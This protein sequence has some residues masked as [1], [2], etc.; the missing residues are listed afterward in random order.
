MNVCESECFWPR[1]PS[2]CL[3]RNDVRGRGEVWLD[4]YRESWDG[5]CSE[6]MRG[7]RSCAVRWDQTRSGCDRH[8]R[9]RFPAGW[10]LLCVCMCVHVRVYTRVYIRLRALAIGKRGKFCGSRDFSIWRSFSARDG[11]SGPLAPGSLF[12]RFL[13]CSHF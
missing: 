2:C 5:P 10:E 9:R 8:V 7:G 11:H 1:S 3:E 6:L 13:S 4:E 12:V